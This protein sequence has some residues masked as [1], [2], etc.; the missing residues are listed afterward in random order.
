MLC[1]SLFESSFS[2]SNVIFLSGIFFGGDMCLVYD[3]CSWT[4]IVH[5][6]LV[7]FRQLHVCSVL[8][9]V[10][11]RIIFLYFSHRSLRIY[12]P[13]NSHTSAPSKLP[14]VTSNILLSFF[15]QVVPLLN[16]RNLPACMIMSMYFSAI[17]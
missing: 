14:I 1:K 12:S 7:V 11:V 15:I 6:A 9:R 3:I 13:T 8:L 2:Q 5:R 10:F 4:I 17:L 16:S